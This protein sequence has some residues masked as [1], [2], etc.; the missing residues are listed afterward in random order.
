MDNIEN[1]VIEKMLKQ[2]MTSSEIALLFDLDVQEV[3]R[4]EDMA[5]EL[6]SSDTESDGQPDEYTEWQDYYDGDDNFRDWEVSD[7]E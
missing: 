3:R 5:C 1:A 7:W 2:G 4:I 6:G